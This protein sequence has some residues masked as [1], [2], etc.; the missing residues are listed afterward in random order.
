MAF[1]TN[2]FRPT[3]WKSGVKKMTDLTISLEASIWNIEILLLS[4]EKNWIRPNIGEVSGIYHEF[5]NSDS[6]QRKFADMIVLYKEGINRLTSNPLITTIGGQSCEIIWEKIKQNLASR[7][8]YPFYHF[9]CFGG[10]LVRHMSQISDFKKFIGVESVGE[11]IEW[12]KNNMLEKDST[13]SLKIEFIESEFD[14]IHF[15]SPSVVLI[16]DF[17]LH[18]KRTEA[19]FSELTRNS[20]FISTKIIN[21]TPKLRFE[22]TSP[23]GLKLTHYYYIKE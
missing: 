6:L 5:R 18:Q 21:Q 19:V 4:K 10:N 9:G 8:N 1:N 17:N 16:N 14:Q 7:E 11:R 12:A 3:L 22:T 23:G 20:H 13:Q 2:Q 15:D